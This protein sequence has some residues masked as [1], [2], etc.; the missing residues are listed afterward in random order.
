MN[1]KE[2]IDNIAA[3]VAISKAKAQAGLETILGTIQ[4]SLKSGDGVQI[5][6]FGSFQVVKTAARNGKNP[7]T[8]QA[9]KIPAK[10]AVKFRVGKALQDSVKQ[11][12]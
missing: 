9:I 11:D 6:G 1:K 7:R 10:K 8:G 5:I 12:A 4:D 2:L 3:D